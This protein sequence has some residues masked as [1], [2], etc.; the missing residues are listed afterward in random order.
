[1]GIILCITDSS[2]CNKERGRISDVKVYK[3]IAKPSVQRQNGINNMN[4]K[5]KNNPG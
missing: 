1:M 5:N 4:S 2:T 3:E